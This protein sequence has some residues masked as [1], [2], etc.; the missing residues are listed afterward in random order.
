MND[1]VSLVRKHRA[2]K[3]ALRLA[4]VLHVVVE[5]VKVREH[6]AP[7]GALRPGL[8]EVLVLVEIEIRKH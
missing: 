2:P 8:H 6:R 1:S 3:G 5:A 7:K 4:M